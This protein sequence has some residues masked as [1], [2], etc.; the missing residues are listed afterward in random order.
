M[1]F[2]VAKAIIWLVFLFFKISINAHLGDVQKCV[3]VPK[4]SHVFNNNPPP[5]LMFFKYTNYI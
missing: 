4:S 3:S 1:F 2:D 5:S